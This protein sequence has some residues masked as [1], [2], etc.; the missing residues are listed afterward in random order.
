[1][2]QYAAMGLVAFFLMTVSMPIW[3][4]DGPFVPDDFVVPEVLETEHFRLRMLSV[5]DVVKDYDAVMS[6]REHLQGSFGPDSDWPNA[7][8][9]LEQNL[10]DL[11]WHQSEFQNRSSF[12]YTVV[13]PDEQ[14]VLGCLYMFPAHRGD[15]DARIIMWVRSDVLDDGYDAL[16]YRAVTAW[17]NEDWPFSNPAYPGRS[18]SWEQ[19]ASLAP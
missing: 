7:D 10:V 18:I 6:S 15:Y 13:S 12:A 19:W 8:M 3:S 4:H 9:T 2:K 16:L 1:M 11:G 14:R 17:V 5:S